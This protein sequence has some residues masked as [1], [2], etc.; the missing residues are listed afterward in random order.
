MSK[1]KRIAIIVKAFFWILV[2]AFFYWVVTNN[3]FSRIIEDPNKF[4][5][6]LTQHITI[7]IVS[8]FIAVLTS[9]PL[10]ILLTRP[11][12]RRG[13]W[14]VVNIANLGQTIPSLAVLALAMGVLGIGMKAAIVAL[15]VYSLLPILQNTIAGIDSVDSKTKDAARGMGLTPKQILWRVELPNAAFSIIAGVRT[16]LVINIGTAALA[17][18]IGGGGLGVWIFT[19]I[20]LFDNTY[21]M[22]GAIP[23]TLLAIL[24]DLGCRVLQFL[25]VPKG[26]R[27]AR[28]AI[29]S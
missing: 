26:L 23:V 11:K 3:M 25:L 15:Y 12:F 8:S 4:F 28:E 7:V 2:L 14:L 24:V 18:L 6:L 27:L 22:S 1:Q 5:T 16:A 10:G 9:I 20:Q 17:Y 13:E 21:L 29:K 19:G